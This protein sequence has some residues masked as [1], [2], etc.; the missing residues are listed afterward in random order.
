MDSL[1][2]LANFLSYEDQLQ[3]V[4]FID[5]MPWDTTLKRRRQQYGYWYDI[6][7]K[8]NAQAPPIPGV[9]QTLAQHLYSE[10]TFAKVPEQLL[11]NE[12]TA[13]QG[14]SAHTDA[15]IFGSV[16]VSISLLEEAEMIFTRESERFSMILEPGSI[17]VMFGEA[18]YEW[19]HE[20]KPTKTYYKNGVRVTKS[21][22]YRRISLTYRT[23]A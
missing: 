10:G 9:L 19:K 4:E 23:L 6:K 2:Y 22:N 11:I 12:Y 1:Y 15:N 20:I 5:S 8:S 16:V 17:L 13:T 7:S 21:A 18:R 14:I 3:I